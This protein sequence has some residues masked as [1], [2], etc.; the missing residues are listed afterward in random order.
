MGVLQS[1]FG[2]KLTETLRIYDR[3]GL[4]SYDRTSALP[5]PQRLSDIYARCVHGNLIDMRGPL[6]AAAKNR[7]AGGFSSE[8]QDGTAAMVDNLAHFPLV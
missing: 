7:E 6:R 1:R 2:A 5:E 8:I 4:N 3:V